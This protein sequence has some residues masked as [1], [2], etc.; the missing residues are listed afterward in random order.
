VARLYETMIACGHPYADKKGFRERLA[1]IVAING[2]GAKTVLAHG[3]PT[4]VGQGLLDE[5]ARLT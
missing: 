1:D 2:D 5:I 3:R 4:R